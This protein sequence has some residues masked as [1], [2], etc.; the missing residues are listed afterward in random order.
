MPNTPPNSGSTEGRPAPEGTPMAEWLK[1]GGEAADVV[2]SSRVRLARNLADFPFTARGDRASRRAVLEA[3]KQAILACGLETPP[4]VR[5]VWVDLH[6]VPHLERSAL[7]ERHLIS[8]QHARGKAPPE[9]AREK[10]GGEDPRAIAYL[11]PSERLAIMVNEEDHLRIQ[12]IRGG[13]ALAEA[14]REID[15]VDDKLEASLTYA[16]SP[17][18]G[19]L[20]ACPTNVGTGLRMSVMLHLPGLKLTGDIEKVKRAAQ[21]ANLAVRGFYGEGSDAAGDY[22]QIS[23]QTTLGK[24]E[25]VILHELQ[26]DI[27]PQV[28]EY[29]RLSRATLMHKRRDTIEDTVFRALG[30]L[31]HARRL[32]TEESMQLL[33]HVRLG[34]AVGLLKSITMPAVNHLTLLIHPA[35]LQRAAGRELDQEQRRTARATLVRQHLAAEQARSSA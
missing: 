31:T 32:T 19:F 20:T 6:D 9:G 29:E 30:I 12:V 26:G 27:I 8:R 11:A 33:S 2:L 23:N 4:V 16:F 3:C 15:A 7:F 1:G 5:L 25:Q 18:F 21:A 13:L 28:I 24:H 10:T 35:H 22:Y 17:R 14:W 34:V